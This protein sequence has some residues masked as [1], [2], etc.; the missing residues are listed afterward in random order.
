MAKNLV[1][2]CD[3][4]CEASVLSACM[5]DPSALERIPWLLPSHFFQG[6]HQ[7]IFE[8]ICSLAETGQ[9]IDVVRVG[10]R[11]KATGRIAQIGGMAYLAEIINS[12]PA[13]SNVGAHAKPIVDH[14]RAREMIATCQRIAAEGYEPI[15]DVDA[16]L[17]RA[18][19]SVHSIATTT[20][21]R[22]TFGHVREFLKAAGRDLRAAAEMG[23]GGVAGFSTGF[24]KVD[25]ITTGLHPGDLYV[26]AAR[27]GMG[28][29]SFA[30]AIARFTARHERKRVDRVERTGA[31]IV[32]AEMP[33]KQ[34]AL[35]SACAAGRVP[36]S[37]ARS[38]RLDAAGMGRLST[39]MIE[40]ASSNLWLDERPGPSLAAVRSVAR[41]AAREARA[42]GARLAVLV[43]DYLQ[44]MVG[45]E[46]NSRTRNR[47]QE[48]AE[49]SRGLKALAKELD[50]AVIAISQ[51]NRSVEQ[52]A[53]KRPM[54]SDLRESGAIEQDADAV[55]FLYR[56]AYYRKRPEKAPTFRDPD[57][58]TT[59]V[60][61]AKQRN[62][63]V[64]MVRVTFDAPS[65]RFEDYQ[66]S[67]AGEMPEDERF[68]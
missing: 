2:P 12:S 40:V 19:S 25:E 38:A 57:E 26:V 5:L 28:K 46:T 31:V 60:I 58:G 62:G 3:L 16:W 1:P 56:D 33:G 13:V 45:S 59:E 11:L 42:A 55:I 43:V 50:I 21:D 66:G 18:E 36:L 68:G 54:L 29:T 27:P 44:L 7:R 64:G 20:P 52:R 30:E 39:A 14:A 51:L 41:S 10:E 67:D 61:V 24:A 35:R 37:R 6:A 53:D 32:S 9:P 63:P 22:K 65:T 49:N 15:E 47:E 4:D 48:I 34:L 17:E 23:S 8:A